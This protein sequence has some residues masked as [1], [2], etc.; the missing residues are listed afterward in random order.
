MTILDRIVNWNK[1]R[2]NMTF[3]LTTEV[4]MLSEE[5]FEL[6]GYNRE[7]SKK[8]ALLF[9]EEHIK[10]DNGNFDNLTEDEIK[11]MIAD[12]AGDLIFIATGTIAKLGLDPNEVMTRICDHNDAKGKK[13]DAFGKILK[14][15]TFIEPKH[16]G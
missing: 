10:L 13:K 6:C 3:K 7:L 4:K 2:D 11:D 8:L 1:E 15:E 5:L 14:D 12:A 9:M 16:V